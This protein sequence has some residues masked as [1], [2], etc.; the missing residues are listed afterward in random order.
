MGNRNFVNLILP[1]Q[2]RVESSSARLGIPCNQNQNYNC[3]SERSEE[4]IVSF[5]ITIFITYPKNSDRHSERNE[6]SVVN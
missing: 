1:H 2:T 5:K 3:Y 6:E 4:F